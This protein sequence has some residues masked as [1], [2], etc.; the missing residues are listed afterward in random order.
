MGSP[1]TQPYADLGAALFRARADAGLSLR[2]TARRLGL[3]AHSG[4]VDYERGSRLIPEDLLRRYEQIFPEY[5]AELR[6]MRRAAL[7]GRAA[8][9]SHPRQLPADLP[10]F[11]GRAGEVAALLNAAGGAGPV[12]VWGAPGLGKTS[13]A[14]HA[15][16]LLLDRYPDGHLYADLTG[17][18]G[19][20][21]APPAVLRQLLRSLGTQRG[22]PQEQHLPLDLAELSAEF[23]SAC[24][25]R[26]LLLLLDNAADEGQVRPVLPAGT[27]CLVLVT[28]RGCLPGLD[29]AQ[30]L[31]LGPLSHAEGTAM[32]SGIV[33][34][35]RCAADPT[36]AAAIVRS[37]AGSPLAIRIAAQRLGMWPDAPLDEFAVLLSDEHRRLSWLSVGDR[38]V[39]SALE[40]SYQA[41]PE[42]GRRM[43][44]LLGLVPGIEVTEAAATA[45]LPGIDGVLD[46]LA[47]VGLVEPAQHAGRYRMHELTALYARE[48]LAADEDRAIRDQAEL[49]YLTWLLTTARDTAARL[50]PLDH[51]SGPPDDPRSPEEVLRWLD[52][53]RDTIAAGI[54]RAAALDRPELVH[55]L[56]HR[57]S[58]YNDLRCHWTD[59]RD[60]AETALE[61]ARRSGDPAAECV[62][63]NALALA[64][65]ASGEPE[66]MARAAARAAAIGRQIAAVEDEAWG[67][68]RLGMALTDLGRYD[69]AVRTLAR[70]RAL[71]EEYGEWWLAAA[72]GN[73]LGHAL[74][75]D[76]AP[77][78]AAD[79]YR[80][81]AAI[82]HE[83][84]E[85]RGE[86]MALVGLG[87]AET[88]LGAAGRGAGHHRVAL[89]LFAAAADAWGLGHAHFWLA[90]ALRELGELDAAHRHL[91]TA[92]AQFD[93]QGDRRRAAAAT[94]ALAGLPADA[95]P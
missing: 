71:A 85:A 16:H 94:E 55:P 21:A 74:L 9:V 42:P 22:H 77:A 76:G 26:R 32:L 88:C 12:V 87:R 62:A 82:F 69:E 38:A 61:L 20:P 86:A 78:M 39:S 10:D 17:T 27:A 44:R 11:T 13:I 93:A 1:S 80:D 34:Q 95:R 57:M 18:G 2:V 72:A 65:H 67:L 89:R 51:A 81:A 70:A 56:V 46:Q 7:A 14:V 43:F 53:E 23:R 54:R 28:S 90:G 45:L 4:L 63:H 41:L 24:F 6:R 49:R 47:G 19:T 25:G 15:A 92:V 37:C 33:G 48:R 30:R 31:R 35:A 75:Q 3:S 84:G 36:A 59:Q 91:R 64:L 8:R 58:W 50:D 52:R 66:M 5:A 29:G 79:V 83:L 60:L 40:L 68:D 73:H